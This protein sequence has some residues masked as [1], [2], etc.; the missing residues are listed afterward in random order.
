MQ[1]PSPKRNVLC[2]TMDGSGASEKSAWL[3]AGQVKC[4]VSGERRVVVDKQVELELFERAS[5]LLGF[6]G[7]RTIGT[8]T[9][10]LLF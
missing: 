9:I 3:G 6:D 2:T 5:C 10:V 4:C 7:G 1:P 8:A